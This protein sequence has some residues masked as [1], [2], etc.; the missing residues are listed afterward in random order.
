MMGLS[1]GRMPGS[2]ISSRLHAVLALGSIFARPSMLHV[3]SRGPLVRKS[4]A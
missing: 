1:A 4:C 3:G 2:C